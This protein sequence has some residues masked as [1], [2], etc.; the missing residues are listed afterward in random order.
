MSF[1]FRSMSAEIREPESSQL[2]Y[3]TFRPHAESI[4]SNGHPIPLAALSHSISQLAVHRSFNEI[5]KYC[6][7]TH[8]FGRGV[9]TKIL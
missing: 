5:D 7:M 2:V 1:V 3:S 6:N 4:S 8:S 9:F